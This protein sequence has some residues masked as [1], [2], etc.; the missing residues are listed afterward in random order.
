MAPPE[1]DHSQPHA[2]APKIAHCSGLHRFTAADALA[3]LLLNL[4]KLSNGSSEPTNAMSGSQRKRNSDNEDDYAALPSDPPTY[5]SIA[6]SWPLNAAASPSCSIRRRRVSPSESRL[7]GV[8]SRGAVLARAS[9]A[10]ASVF[11]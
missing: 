3:D 5:R 4:V 8:T 2:A 6:G 11:H 9:V 10:Q 7:L 1:T